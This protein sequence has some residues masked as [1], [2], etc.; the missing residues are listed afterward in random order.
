MVP[1]LLN[2]LVT[3]GNWKRLITPVHPPRYILRVLFAV[4]CLLLIGAMWW[5]FH[6]ATP[7]PD[8]PYM[9]AF[10]PSLLHHRGRFEEDT[11]KVAMFI[12]VGIFLLL[13]PGTQRSRRG[14]IVRAVWWGMA[15]SVILQVGRYFKPGRLVDPMDV[16]ANTVGIFLG[17]GIIFF[18]CL[19]RKAIAWLTTACIFSFVLAATWP[20]HF[21][22]QAASRAALASRI[23]WSPFSGGLNMSILR[24][25]ALNGLMMMPLGLLAAT[26]AM[27]SR[28]V[29]TA[30]IYATTL[31]LCSS[32]S[33]ELLQCFLPNRT[34]SLSD[35][36]LNTLGTLAGALVAVFLERWNVTTFQSR[37]NSTLENRGA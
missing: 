13:L 8:Q 33:V 30:L 2:F 17:V 7:Q 21:S 9:A 10:E 27:R 18:Q 1:V 4:Y 5:P 32:V 20:M 12:P 11:L 24:E 26:C 31:G 36:S 34:P 15:F 16:A 14:I 37:P 28:G 3:Q 25:R 23:E 29:R 6:F 35:I 22:F 19:S